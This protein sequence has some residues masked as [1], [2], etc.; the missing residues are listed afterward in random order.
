M[1][2]ALAGISLE[3]TARE[4]ALGGIIGR[5]SETV[6]KTG[7]ISKIGNSLV[8]SA[9]LAKNVG[10][11]NQWSL[12]LMHAFHSLKRPSN[13]IPG[14]MHPS[15]LHSQLQ[16][17]KRVSNP[18]AGNSRL[19]SSVVNSNSGERKTNSGITRD[20]EVSH[21]AGEHLERT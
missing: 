4:V 16:S 20:R 21:L 14:S 17:H 11:Y 13:D 19:V 6:V 7:A 10:D 15:Y 12:G 18:S 9:S 3:D 8:P 2:R 5:T 1:D